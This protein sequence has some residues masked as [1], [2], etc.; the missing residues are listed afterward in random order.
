MIIYKK[1]VPGFVFACIGFC[2]AAT[3]AVVLASCGSDTRTT[4][5]TLMVSIEPLRYIVE[6]ITGDDFDVAVLVPLGASPETYE[7]TPFQIKAAEDASLVFSTGLIGFE[8]A[9][10]DRLTLPERL[11]DLSQGIELITAEPEHEP[12]HDDAASA[13]IDDRSSHTHSHG[14]VDPHI[15][16]S[17]KA[18]AQMAATAYERIHELYPDS[19]SYTANYTRLAERLEALDREV[20]DRLAASPT[21]SFMIF[22][23]GL[24]YYAR[25]YGLQQIALETDGKEPSSKQL[26]A[27]IELARAEGISGILYQREF[28]RR[29][30][31]VVAEEIGAEPVE[32]DILSYDIINNILNI[33][34][35]I[36]ATTPTAPPTTAHPSETR[37]PS[38]G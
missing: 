24:T 34:E 27:K 5:K 25:D 6:E 17:P 1:V 36:A 37:K 12:K 23:P 28:P 31:E 19:V 11:V 2:A 16:V 38:S 15:W 14:G 32:I 33:T 29:I 3:A 21:R 30:V 26:A 4:D 13:P 9:L 20:A 18:L 8:N 10:M 7:P 35:L 22:H